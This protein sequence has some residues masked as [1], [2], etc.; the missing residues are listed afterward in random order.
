MCKKCSR[1]HYD[2]LKVPYFLY[3]FGS[4]GCFQVEW[5]QITGM[6]VLSSKVDR[7]LL[8]FSRRII[9][10]ENGGGETYGEGRI[11]GVPKLNKY[12]TCCY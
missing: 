11:L 2:N 12:K 6:F 8:F 5:Q 7:C 9:C 1:E 3:C 10:V 4:H